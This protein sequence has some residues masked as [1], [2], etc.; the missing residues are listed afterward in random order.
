[1]IKKTSHLPLVFNILGNSSA[2][3]CEVCRGGR[4]SG[5]A[6]TACEK[7]EPG[8]ADKDNSSQT[9]C[10]I[11]PVGS[12]SR[13]G[14]TACRRCMGGYADTD[15]NPRT[16]CV[17]CSRGLGRWIQRGVSI[18]DHFNQY[19]QYTYFAHNIYEPY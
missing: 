10:T 18:A 12:Y 3:A 4:Y 5:A 9:A 11:C 7:C 6:A 14:K 17:L 2:T 8:L 1:M 13:A 19:K 16:P 15:S